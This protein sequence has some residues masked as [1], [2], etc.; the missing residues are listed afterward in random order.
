[1]GAHPTPTVRVSTPTGSI[2]MRYST[3]GKIG[4]FLV[5]VLLPEGVGQGSPLL[6]NF[7]FGR[8]G[9]FVAK[10]KDRHYFAAQASACKASFCSPLLPSG[11]LWFSRGRRTSL[12]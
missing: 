4:V 11:V 7:P 2:Q 12:R 8:V 6:Q 1:M 9:L 5:R 3:G 10:R